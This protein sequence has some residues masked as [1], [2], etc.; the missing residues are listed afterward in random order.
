MYTGQTKSLKSV[1][2]KVF[3]NPLV[4]DLAYEQAAEFA[5]EAIRLIGAPLAYETKVTKPIQVVDHKALGPI[6]SIKTNGI[7]AML[8]PNAT[9]EEKYALTYATDTFH[10]NAGCDGDC[11]ELLDS[12]LTYTVQSN[13]ITTSFKSGYIQISYERLA[14]D[15]DDFPLVPDD[16]DTLLAIEYYILFR[17]F[18]PLWIM[19]KITDKAFNYIDTKK[20]WYM[21][22][23]NTS[24]T[25][26]GPDHLEAVMNTINRLIVN[27]NAHKNFFKE[28]GKK[29]KFRRYN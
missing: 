7:R 18:E 29:E 20:C 24:L 4:A 22:A 9:D 3:N 13:I 14:V 26:E 15:E 19:G 10:Q 8:D 27:T 1:L 11:V 2:W 17:Y 28:A 21:G 12:E 5:I 23:A 16:Q 6:N 25:L